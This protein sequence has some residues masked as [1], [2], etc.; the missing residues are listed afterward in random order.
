MF[1]TFVSSLSAADTVICTD[2]YAARE[3]DTFGMSS[4]LLCSGIS[5]HTE[6]FYARSY[7]EAAEMAVKLT[8]NDGIILVLG[9]GDV[10][11][12]ADI[13]AERGQNA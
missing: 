4:E 11:K 5:A 3:T 1:D 13:A 6:C 10:Y 7:A 12:C 8:R 9:A 2:I